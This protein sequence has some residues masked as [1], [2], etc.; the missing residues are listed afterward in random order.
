[1]RPVP[2]NPIDVSADRRPRHHSFSWNY[3]PC[4]GLL[5]LEG[6]LDLA[7]IEELRTALAAAEDPARTLTVDLAGLDFIDCAGLACIFR[8]AGRMSRTGRRL[9]LEGD[10]GQVKRLLDLTGLSTGVERLSEG[11]HLRLASGP[12]AGAGATAPDGRS[13]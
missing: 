13:S 8:L 10:H 6:E 7:R 11:P 1:M 4:L 12:W 9:V 5:R 2:A 3:V